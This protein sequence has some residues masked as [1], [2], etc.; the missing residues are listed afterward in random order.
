MS[1]KDCLYK[2]LPRLDKPCHLNLGNAEA[3]VLCQ[4]PNS[5]TAQSLS[6]AMALAGQA[7][8]EDAWAAPV[9]CTLCLLQ[10]QLDA[11]G[12]AALLPSLL[13]LQHNDQVSGAPTCYACIGMFAALSPRLAMLTVA[14]SSLLASLC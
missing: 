12:L 4:V 11:E 9:L 10:H 3:S 7:G 6:I 5:D 14:I 2:V 1:M 8:I 13:R